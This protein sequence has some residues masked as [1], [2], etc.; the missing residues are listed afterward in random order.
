M[1]MPDARVRLGRAEFALGPAELAPALLGAV[2]VRALPTGQ[3]LAGVIVETEA[4][5]GVRDRAAHSFGGRRTARVEPMYAAPGTA[6]VYFT[7]GMHHCMNVV[8]GEVGE[9][10]AVL[11][12]ALAPVEGLDAMRRFR[13]AKAERELCSGPGKLCQALAI[14]RSLS[15]VDLTSS[16]EVWIEAGVRVRPR[17]VVRSPRVGV[18][19]AGAWAARLLRFSVR[20][21]ESVSVM[22]RER[23]NRTGSQSKPDRTRE[24]ARSSSS[25][26][27][28]TRGKA[29]R[30]SSVSG[31]E[32]SSK[33][34]SDERG[35]P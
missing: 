17:D 4:Y 34:G 3:R 27:R 20:G 15:G 14:D 9:P 6:Y 19:Y 23:V 29:G 28:K 8:C 31:E 25:Q 5:L 32:K 1:R 7:Y 33:G 24:A 22:P 26:A 13:G 18:S 10:V 16:D 2:L 12:R 30:G 35:G 11:L 21:N